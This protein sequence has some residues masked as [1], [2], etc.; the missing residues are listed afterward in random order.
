MGAM[1][2]FAVG[3]I[4]LRKGVLRTDGAII[5]AAKPVVTKDKA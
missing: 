3:L 5:M 1:L 4:M 2:I